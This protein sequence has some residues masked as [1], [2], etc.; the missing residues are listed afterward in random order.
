ME[1]RL[2]KFF[3]KNKLPLPD[4][5]CCRDNCVNLKPNLEQINIIFDKFNYL[6]KN[7]ICIVA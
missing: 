6:N 7:N 4:F 5:I 3:I 1:G 2:R